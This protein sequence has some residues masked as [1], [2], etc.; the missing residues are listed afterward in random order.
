MRGGGGSSLMATVLEAKFLKAGTE[1][2]LADYAFRRAVIALLI[3]LTKRGES[4][5]SKRISE[6]AREQEERRKAESA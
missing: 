1:P 5:I 3:V 4:M 2:S 6:L